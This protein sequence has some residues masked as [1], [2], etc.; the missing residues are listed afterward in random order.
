MPAL[1]QKQAN[2]SILKPI[3]VQGPHLSP[4]NR[5]SLLFELL[6]KCANPCNGGAERSEREARGRPI[7]TASAREELPPRVI[8]AFTEK[9]NF[10]AGFQQDGGHDFA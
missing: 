3:P 9:S 10:G 7:G 2:V 4:K 1:R 6:P 8:T 5:H